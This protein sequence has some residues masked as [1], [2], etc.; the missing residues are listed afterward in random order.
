M[1]TE[2][3]D[4]DIGVL[5]RR[6]RAD[7]QMPTVEVIPTADK[8]AVLRPSRAPAGH[9]S[10][11]RPTRAIDVVA[12]IYRAIEINPMA[13]P[14][15]VNSASPAIDIDI[16]AGFQARPGM[17][18]LAHRTDSQLVGD[19]VIDPHSKSAGRKVVAVRIVISVDIDKVTESCHP[20]AP[21]VLR[22]GLKNR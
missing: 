1:L 19:A 21:A 15:G 22:S 3:I 20:H 2:A 4:V 7:G 18:V 10:Q 14:S 17:G 16:A 9:S 11:R 13:E 5:K 6:G 12:A 8:G